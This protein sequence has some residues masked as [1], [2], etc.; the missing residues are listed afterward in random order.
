MNYF[1][2]VESEFRS[3]IR[4][5]L[6]LIIGGQV[7]EKKNKLMNVLS[8]VSVR[9]VSSLIAVWFYGLIQQNVNFRRLSSWTLVA[10]F[11]LLNLAKMMA[12]MA[13]DVNLQNF[14]EDA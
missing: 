5:L 7:P 14:N 4:Y 8:K 9:A 2:L 12:M 3:L 11:V 1:I 13:V 10:I 6:Q